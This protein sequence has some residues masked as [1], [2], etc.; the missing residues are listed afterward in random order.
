MFFGRTVHTVQWKSVPS[1]KVPNAAH[2]RNQTVLTEGRAAVASASNG[3]TATTE[4]APQIIRKRARKT[5]T[6]YASSN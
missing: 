2:G 3:H 6:S 1:R 4:R 5:R